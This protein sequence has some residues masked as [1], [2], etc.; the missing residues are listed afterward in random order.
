MRRGVKMEVDLK[1]MFE[2]AL[3]EIKKLTTDVLLYKTLLIQKE[4]DIEDNEKNIEILGKK[5]EELEES[6]SK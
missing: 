1:I 4:K 5:I 6:K 3:D 2:N